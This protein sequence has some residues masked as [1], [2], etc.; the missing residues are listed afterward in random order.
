MTP[1]RNGLARADAYL[2]LMQDA[3]WDSLTRLRSEAPEDA[4]IVA[5]WD[6]GYFVEYV[7]ERRSAADGG[8]LLTHVPHWI[9]RA[10]LAQSERESAGLLRMLA[11]GS[12]AT[13][14]P[15]GGRGAWGKLVAHGIDGATAHDLVVALASLDRTAAAERLRAAGLD[16]AAVEDVLASTHCTPPATYVVMSSTQAT[17]TTWTVLG[18]WSDK[19][20][21][22]ELAGDATPCRLDGHGMRSC[23]VHA[24][25][26]DSLIERFV[27]P[28]TDPVAGRLVIQPLDGGR[29]REVAPAE[30]ML[31]AD[32][33]VRSVEPSAEDRSPIGVLI[34]VERDRVVVGTPALLRSTF[35]RLMFLGDVA[36]SPFEKVDERTAAGER[37]VTWRI[38][39]G[40]GTGLPNAGEQKIFDFLTARVPS[41][42][43]WESEASTVAPG[44]FGVPASSLML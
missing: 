40:P 22:L 21:T 3:W 42:G 26:E 19:R 43:S 1:L 39:Y 30:V 27:Y 41:N 2:P 4:V 20:E 35:A 7:A 6:W 10:L 8:T 17:A 36:G 15:E 18:S 12:D 37:I 9:A 38:R 16:A 28:E 34:D 33:H 5:W 24:G 31:A 29:V 14:Q 44:N 32:G 11:C 25:F 23:A 13:P